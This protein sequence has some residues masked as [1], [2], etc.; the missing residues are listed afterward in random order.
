M[1]KSGEFGT[2][3]KWR[4][5]MRVGGD[6]PMHWTHGGR[7]EDRGKKVQGVPKKSWIKELVGVIILKNMQQP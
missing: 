1:R 5:R 4:P 2:V 6:Q 3:N 7:D